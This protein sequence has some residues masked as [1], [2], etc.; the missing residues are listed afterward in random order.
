MIVLAAILCAIAGAVIGGFGSYMVMGTLGVSDFEG[1]RAVT[2]FIVFAPLG[3]ITG[4]VVGI[5]LARKLGP[6]KVV[7]PLL[8]ILLGGAALAAV[9][10]S[11]L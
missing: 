4:L 5:L 6:N 10:E 2:A 9:A 3:A 1:M 7:L 8:A 11:W